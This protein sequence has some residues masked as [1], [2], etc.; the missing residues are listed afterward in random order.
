MFSRRDQ[1][2]PVEVARVDGKF[3]REQGDALR[4][5]RMQQGIKVS[6]RYR[7]AHTRSVGGRVWMRV[8]GS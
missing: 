7:S 1:Q 6:A 5:A 3:V 8:C 2:N 4:N